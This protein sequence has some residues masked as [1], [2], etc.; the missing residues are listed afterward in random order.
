M[1]R[2]EFIIALIAAFAGVAEAE[3]QKKLWRIGVLET[4]PRQLNSENMNAFMQGLRE[5]GYEEGR[6]LSLDYRSVEGNTERL[7]SV[8]SELV[9]SNLDL[10]A[11]RGTP[12]VLALHQ[13]TITI[14]V[15]ML[16]VVDPVDI[17]VASS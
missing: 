12:E 1:R 8:V 10:I 17:G 7:T 15:V 5:L 13:Q 14:P 4:T 16:A 2:R 6:N 11:V 9:R 3:P